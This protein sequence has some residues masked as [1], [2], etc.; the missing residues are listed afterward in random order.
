MR[1]ENTNAERRKSSESQ[2]TRRKS[3]Q[4]ILEAEHFRETIAQPTGMAISEQFHQGGNVEMGSNLEGRS[5]QMPN[6]GISNGLSNDDFF[7]LTCHLEPSLIHKI[8]AFRAY[9]TIYCAAHPQRAKEIWQYVLV[10]HTAYTAYY[11][12]NVY[13]YDITFRHLMAFNPSHSWAVMY[14]QMWN[15]SM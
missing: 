4:A 1:L 5:P 10:I 6:L 13:N 2:E 8:E 3:D 12:E 14:N 7:H 9:A 15:L 11:W